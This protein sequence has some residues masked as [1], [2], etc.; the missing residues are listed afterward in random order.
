MPHFCGV[1]TMSVSKKKKKKINNTIIRFYCGT[2]RQLNF[3][4]SIIFR[5]IWVSGTLSQA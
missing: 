5:S 3:K 4:L 1:V 2:F